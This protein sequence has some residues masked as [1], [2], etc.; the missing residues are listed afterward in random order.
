[1]FARKP[2][3]DDKID[4][5]MDRVDAALE[6]ITRRTPRDKISS[7]TPING[8]HPTK[9]RETRLTFKAFTEN[10]IV[11]QSGDDI[12]LEQSNEDA[13]CSPQLKPTVAL[14]NKKAK[15]ATG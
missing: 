11:S 5:C 3:E 13:Q 12:L 4:A 7:Q 10:P 9:C 2:H 8:F 14:D 6:K 15:R 1:M